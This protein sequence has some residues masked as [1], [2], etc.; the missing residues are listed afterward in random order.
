MN[1]CYLAVSSLH[2]N[3]AKCVLVILNV[4]ISILSLDLCLK[5]VQTKGTCWANLG[6]YITFRYL[7]LAI[8]L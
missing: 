4:C 1:C 2:R 6:V 5:K 3:M 8:L 7:S